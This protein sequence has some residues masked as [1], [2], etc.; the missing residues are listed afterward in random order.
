MNAEEI[1]NKHL[2]SFEARRFASA[3]G[4]ALENFRREVRLPLENEIRELRRTLSLVAKHADFSQ[5]PPDV[6]E[7]VDAALSSPNDRGVPCG[8]QRPPVGALPKN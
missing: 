7:A 6:E 8:G 1:L 3:S 4:E 5:C 2:D